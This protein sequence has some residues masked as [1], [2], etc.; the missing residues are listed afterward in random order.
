MLLESNTLGNFP[1]RKWYAVIKRTICSEKCINGLI[2][3]N[4]SFS[5][6]TV[7]GPK[8]HTYLSN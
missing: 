8:T 4:Q 6:R 1:K 2:D 3:I 7:Y 5:N